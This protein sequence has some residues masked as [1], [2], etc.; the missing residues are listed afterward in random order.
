[1]SKGWFKD[2]RFGMFIHWGAYSAAERGEWTFNREYISKEEYIEKY[3]NNFKAENYDPREWAKLA[4]KT[5]MKYMVLTTRH[6]DG[7][8][9]FDTKTTDFNAMNYGPKKDLVKEYADAVRAE[10]L[11]VGFYFSP[12]DWNHPDYPG[13][14]LRDWPT[15]WTDEEAR[16]RFVAYYKEQLRELMTNYGK[17]DVLWYDGCIPK[18]LDGEEVNAMVRELQP[19]IMIN[20]RNG[21]PYDYVVSERVVQAPEKDIPWEA[22]MT[23]NDNWGYHSGDMDYK[24][25]KDVLYML[26]AAATDG[27][28]LLLNVGPKA[29]GTIPQESVDILNKVAE[30]M[31]KNGDAIYG[32]QRHPFS[33][34]MSHKLTVKD[35]TVYVHVTH[36]MPENNICIAEIKNK[37]KR[38]YKVSTGEEHRFE[39]LDNGRLFIYDINGDFE[40]DLILTYAVE[41]EGKPE[42]LISSTTFWIPGM[43]D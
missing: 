4:K 11:K 36:K 20:A 12:A 1:M 35:S 25:P 34:G 33:W 18:P 27:G 21:A 7:Y 6:H 43:E 10:G 23:L 31:D 28:N 3:V 14:Y 8:A 41:I 9:L 39:Q 32:T 2:A 37:V 19:D 38:V 40:N 26:L 42:A 15:E 30:W 29:D 16:C 17:I 13:A 5:G 24:S 22:C